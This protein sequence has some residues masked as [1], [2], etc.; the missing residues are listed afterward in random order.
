MVLQEW[1]WV[2][3]PIDFAY[4]FSLM[5]NTIPVR[6]TKQADY[7][8]MEVVKTLL[9][10]PT[11]LL[12]GWKVVALNPP[13]LEAANNS[14]NGSVIV[15]KD[16]ERNLPAAPPMGLDL[17]Y[18]DAEEGNLGGPEG[19]WFGGR[20]GDQWR[21]EGSHGVVARENRYME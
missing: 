15:V 19:A 11:G 5:S 13:I 18:Y 2:N 20:N 8:M 16:V 12:A 17:S 1:T 7:D 14:F 10:K 9:S 6:F 21:N 3:T 4:V